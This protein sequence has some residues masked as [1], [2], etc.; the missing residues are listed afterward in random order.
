VVIHKYGGI[1]GSISLRNMIRM[2]LISSGM[3]MS[4]MEVIITPGA[5][6]AFANTSLAICDNG[7]HTIMIAPYYFSHLMSLQLAGVHVHICPFDEKTLLPDWDALR[8]LINEVK[9]NMIIVTTPNNPSGLVWSLENLRCLVELCKVADSW[10]VIDQTYAEFLYDETKHSIPCSTL[11][12]YPKIIHIFSF[13]KTFGM[14]GWR[15]GYIVTPNCL[16]NSFRKIQDAHPT[17]AP[18]CSQTLA[19][20]CLLVDKE[21]KSISDDNFSWV[22]SR[23]NS[24][25][26]VR[27]AIWNV[28]HKVG[29]VK[30]FGA[31]YFLVPVPSRVSEAE[32]VD[33]LALSF[34]VLLMTGSSFGAPGYMRLSYGSIVPEKVMVACSRLERGIDALL[35]LSKK[36]S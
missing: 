23:I 3:D 30:T 1:F 9:P 34:G 29:T 28:V 24:L 13:S 8:Q 10:I 33:I 12:N 19:E 16:V 25:L 17:H 7:Q 15:V 4:E 32:A 11:L 6:Q 2:K 22:E 26:P 36:R 35:E 21:T 31:F 14:P 5:N 20:H 27:E 18:V